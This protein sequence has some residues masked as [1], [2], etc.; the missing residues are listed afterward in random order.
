M[1]RGLILLALVLAGPAVALAMDEQIQS[2]AQSP[3]GGLGMLDDS[4]TALQAGGG[5]PAPPGERTITPAVPP[6]LL[7]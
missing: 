2:V 4:T 6:E 1:S 3:Q 7:D 5:A